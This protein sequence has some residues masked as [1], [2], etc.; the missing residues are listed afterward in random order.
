MKLRKIGE[1]LR[2]DNTGGVFRG[3]LTLTLGN[4]AAKI[5]GAISIP[6]L[7]RIYSPEDYGV[8]SVFSSLVLIFAPILTLRYVL[9][10]PLPRRDGVA[11]N[12]LILSAVLSLIMAIAVCLVLW[13]AGPILFA[14]L[15]MEVLIP[16]TWLVLLGLIGSS[17]YEMLSM[18]ATRK[19]FYRS[20]AQTLAFQGVLGAVSKVL[21]GALGLKPLGLLIG[22]VI[23]SSAGIGYFMRQFIK[24]FRSNLRFISWKRLKSVAYIYR[25]FPIYRLPS[26]LLLNFSTQAPALMVAAIYDAEIAGYL[27]LAFMALALPMSLLGR[28]MSQAYYAEISSIGRRKPQVVRDLTYKVIVRLLG[29]SIG[30]AVI[31]LFFGPEIFSMVFGNA[32]RVSGEIASILAIYLVFQ[33]LQAPVAH[34]LYV[35]EG[36]K[37]LL[38]LNVQRSVLTL[39][40][41][42]FAHYRGLDYKGAILLYSVAL[43]IHYAFSIFRSIREIPKQ[44]THAD[45]N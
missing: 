29:F 42:V 44:V 17:G 28:T 11:M 6:V 39:L 1:I 37:I 2:G 18:W 20:M 38:F 7:T 3:M 14:A 5:I 12:L 34:I 13:I 27:G 22:Q 16:W 45:V 30:P 31:L 24:E 36:Q 40:C 9:A 4:G 8:L 19:K 23:S 32:W 25:G 10:T 43:S 35:F 33:F 41:F 15:S 21:L 26:Q